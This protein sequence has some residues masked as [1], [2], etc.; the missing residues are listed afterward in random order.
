VCQVQNPFTTDHAAMLRKKGHKVGKVQ[1]VVGSNAIFV[2][3]D[4]VLMPEQDAVAVAQG[5]T[6]VQE[7]LAR[8]E[9]KSSP[10]RR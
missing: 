6:T 10:V 2:E 3:V 4:G 1:G 7:V 5:R 9:G 8:I